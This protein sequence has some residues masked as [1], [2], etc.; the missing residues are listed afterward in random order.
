MSVRQSSILRI[1]V[2]IIAYLRKEYIIKAV[3]SVLDQN[4]IR[5]KYEIIVVKNFSDSYIDDFLLNHSI[6]NILSTNPEIGKKFTEG[7]LLSTGE[8]VCFLEDD[9]LFSKDK[10]IEV[11]QTFTRYPNLIYY[12]NN[13]FF[14][15]EIGSP[16]RNFST[17]ISRKISKK[18][19]LYVKSEDKDDTVFKLFYLGAY[20]NNSCISIRKSHFLSNLGI[21]SN[22][23]TIFD[24]AIFFCALCSK[25]D[26]LLTRSELNYYRVSRNS[27]TKIAKLDDNAHSAIAASNLEDNL[28]IESMVSESLGKKSKTFERLITD[29][30]YWELKKLIYSNSTKRQDAVKYLIHAVQEYGL[31]PAIIKSNLLQLTGILIF[32]FSPKM[33]RKSKIA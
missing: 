23:K 9:D 12:H 33:S 32:L 7:L 17:V 30:M 26:I 4:F 25:G 15:D 21:L 16:I 6:I 24:G 11:Y 3:E 28:I 29:R 20:W 14:M 1:S 10:L 19:D 18:A 5:D 31:S 8:I 22:I 27:A 13:A 2:I